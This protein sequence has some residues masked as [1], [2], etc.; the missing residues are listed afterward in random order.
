MN[1]MRDIGAFLKAATARAIETITAGAGNDNVAVNGP[2]IDLSAMKE[3]PHSAKIIFFGAATL[4][5]T[6]TLKLILAKLQDATDGSGTGAADISGEALAGV[7][8]TLATGP[9]GGG[10][11]NFI[12]SYDIVNLAQARQA[13]RLVSTVD[14]SR[15]NT[16]TTTVAALMVLGGFDKVPP[17]GTGS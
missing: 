11:V 16:D 5:A 17:S 15:A 12:Q 9:G 1:V 10:T 14:L 8:I 4:A 7:P 2:W 3:R 13:V 6:E